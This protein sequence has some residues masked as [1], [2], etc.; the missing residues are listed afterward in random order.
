MDRIEGMI[1]RDFKGGTGLGGE[2][3]RQPVE[4]SDEGE[5]SVGSI[6]ED[7]EQALERIEL[8]LFLAALVLGDLAL[9]EARPPCQF[10]LREAP[11][12]S[13]EAQSRA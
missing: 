2:G 1:A 7:P 3:I 8:G 13:Q 11:E 5:E 10:Q 9:A 6:V 12:L 4:E